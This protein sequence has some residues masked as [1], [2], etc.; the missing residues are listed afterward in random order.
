MN[1]IILILAGIIAYLLTK[2]YTYL[3][4]LAA[5]YEI[6]LKTQKR[7]KDELFKIKCRKL[8]NNIYNYYMDEISITP[9]ITASSLAN[10]HILRLCK[11]NE[12]DKM[13]SLMKQKQAI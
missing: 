7:R 4:G 1:I 8:K 3:S 5:K 10:M 13:Y 9:E 2:L 11:N 12:I 6:F